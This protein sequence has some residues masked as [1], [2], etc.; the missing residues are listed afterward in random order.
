MNKI[1]KTPEIRNKILFSIFIVFIFRI[2]AH[3]PVPGVNAE[4]IKGYLEQNAFLGLFNIF[5]GG[6]FQNFSIVTLGVN[7]YITSSIIVQMF[8]FLVP[9]LEKL[10]KEEGEAG[11]EKINLYTRLL[12]IPTAF[13]QA[14]GM[15]FFLSRQGIIPGLNLLDLITLIFTLTSG[16]LV[17]MWLGEL[18]TEKGIG[19]GV[20]LIIFAG[21]ASS[22][23]TIAVQTFSTLTGA[24]QL[25]NLIA[26]AVMV[27]LTIA[28]VVLVNEGTRNVPLQYGRTGN[29]NTNVSNYL[30]IK[31]NQAGVMPIIFAVSLIMV[32]AFIAGPL[33]ASSNLSLQKF[34]IFLAQN[35]S[36][37]TWGYNILY[38]VLVF[39]FTFF[40]TSFQF[41]PEKISEDLKKRGA[42]IP[43]VRPGSNTT[44]YLG[45]VIS[46]ITFFGALFLGLIAILPFLVQTGT[47]TANLSVGGSSLLIAVS[48]VL[49]IKRQIN[50]LDVS[51]NYY[52]FLE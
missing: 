51:K 26:I 40:Y 5:S 39:A 41:N 2:L 1:F 8:T 13:I 33:Q 20:S 7:P 27:V 6:A 52:K 48:V 30:P 36:A 25:P 50:S 19:N 42:Y 21:I 47:G 46:R 43:G 22:L 28:G 35:F 23:P 24:D 12:T 15:Y 32:P 44:K 49:E 38:F 10:S 29:V 3:V 34:G 4:L 45:Q 9:E 16:S 17:L 14:Y 37:N 31:V 11:R 18:V